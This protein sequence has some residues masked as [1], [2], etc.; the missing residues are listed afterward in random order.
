MQ[1][2]NTELRRYRVELAMHHDNVSGDVLLT[3]ANCYTA[4]GALVILDGDLGPKRIFA[5]GT[6]LC[7][8]R[9]D[10]CSEQVIAENGSAP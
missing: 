1:E 10:R 3:G 5:P 9:V 8:A 7:C 4:S 6:W 2:L